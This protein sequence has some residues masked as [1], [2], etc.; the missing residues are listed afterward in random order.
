M[1]LVKGTTPTITITC[2]TIDVSLI[3]VAYLI[4]KDGEN[5]IV[6][7]PISDATIDDNSLL[8]KMTQREALKLNVGRTVRIFCDWRLVDG[9]RGRSNISEYTVTETG[10][11]E[12]I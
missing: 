3:D 5:V 7:K 1:E 11:N 12:V 4:I 10:K 9:T 8:W 6:E 2:P